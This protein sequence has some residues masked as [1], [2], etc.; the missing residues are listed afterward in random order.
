MK[1]HTDYLMS[2]SDD[3]SDTELYKFAQAI[4]QE[5]ET[6]Y[7]RKNHGLF[8][9][10]A[11]LD[12]G[13]QLKVKEIRV[14]DLVKRT[15]LVVRAEVYQ[16]ANICTPT[17]DNE[18]RQEA[19]QEHAQFLIEDFTQYEGEWTGSDYWCFSRKANIETECTVDELEENQVKKVAERLVKAIQSN[20][21]VKEFCLAVT[22]L[23][24]DINNLHKLSNK[25]LNI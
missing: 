19:L 9:K 6:N 18:K 20:A 3:G 4:L 5:I 13:G 24:N 10:D 16:Y 12:P 25:D 2:G 14:L 22:D 7:G 11:D 21:Q 1:G 15:N 8:G 23:Y 17:D